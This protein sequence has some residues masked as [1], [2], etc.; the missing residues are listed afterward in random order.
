MLLLRGGLR[1]IGFTV[2][3]LATVGDGGKGLD[4]GEGLR[5]G[6]KK[7]KDGGAAGWRG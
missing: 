3:S 7:E 4:G 2:W 6:W 1:F 5:A